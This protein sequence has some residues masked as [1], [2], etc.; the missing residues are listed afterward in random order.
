MAYSGSG[1]GSLGSDPLADVID[2]DNEYDFYSNN[3][4][5]PDFNNGDIIT[6]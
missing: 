4:A 1:C 6:L 3:A 5:N 2:Y